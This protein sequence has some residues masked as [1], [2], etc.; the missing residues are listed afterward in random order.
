[1]IR[2]IKNML[3]SISDMFMTMA[4]SLPGMKKKEKEDSVNYLSGVGAATETPQTFHVDRHKSKRGRPKGAT[5]E[6]KS[7]AS[8]RK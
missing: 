7:K 1:M 4:A 3:M 8:K 6:K 2:F 5:N